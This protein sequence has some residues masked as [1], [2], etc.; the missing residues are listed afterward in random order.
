MPHVALDAS[1]QS[2]SLWWRVL[3][4]AL[5]P[6]LIVSEWLVAFGLVQGIGTLLDPIMRS[7]FRVPGAGGVVVL[8]GFVSGYP[9]AAKFASQLYAARMLQSNE[10]HRLIAFATTADPLFILSVVA[11]GFFRDVA[12]APVLLVAHYGGAL[13]LG[14]MMRP[15]SSAVSPA[16]RL[17]IRTTCL[18]AYQTM[19]R[20]RR[21]DGRSLVQATHDGIRQAFSLLLLIG[22]LVVVCSVVLALCRATPFYA[23]LDVFLSTIATAWEWPHAVLTAVMEGTFEVTLG[24]QRV[25]EATDASLRWRVTVTSFLLAW[26]GFAVHTQV[27]SLATA[28]KLRYLDLMRARGMHGLLAAVIAFLGW[29]L[30]YRP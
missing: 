25:G 21:A 16:P 10:A 15:A 9:V 27:M 30:L 6:F 24:T 13:L 17:C 28:T 8:M 5:L 3:M 19:L 4:P 18:H 22:G 7:L 20:T 12:T 29:G 23:R 14:L 1:L 26:A 11:L 2:V